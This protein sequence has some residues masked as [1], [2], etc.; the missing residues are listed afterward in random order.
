MTILVTQL[1][2]HTHTQQQGM[3]SIDIILTQPCRIVL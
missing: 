3:L 2:L 1:E